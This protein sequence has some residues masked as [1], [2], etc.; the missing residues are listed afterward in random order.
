MLGSFFAIH[1]E[2]T[3]RAPQRCRW[4]YGTQP[5]AF[6]LNQPLGKHL[7]P[8]RRCRVATYRKWHVLRLQIGEFGGQG[9]Q[10][11]FFG[12]ELSDFTPSGYGWGTFRD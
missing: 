10:K 12:E 7:N 2:P 4:F 3:A 6:G 1:A 11:Q 8:P 9:H 5:L